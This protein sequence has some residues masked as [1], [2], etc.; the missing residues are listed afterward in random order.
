M[1]DIEQSP[2]SAVPYR[3]PINGLFPRY[4]LMV[5]AEEN[6]KSFITILSPKY[7]DN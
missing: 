3:Y 5:A 2:V 4:S 1:L 7:S 6:E